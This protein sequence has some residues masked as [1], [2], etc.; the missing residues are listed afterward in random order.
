MIIILNAFAADNLFDSAIL[1]LAAR[2][3]K[4]DYILKIQCHLMIWNHIN[5]QTEFGDEELLDVVL[6]H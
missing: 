5:I 1:D 2:I 4:S 6:M 3:Q